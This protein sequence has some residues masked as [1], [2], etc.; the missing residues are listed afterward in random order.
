[1]KSVRNILYVLF[2]LSVVT[3][4]YAQY[5][6][7]TKRKWALS[8]KASPW[9]RPVLTSNPSDKSMGRRFSVFSVMGEYYLPKKITAEAG[10]FRAEI[11][12]GGHTRT[13]EGLQLGGKKRFVDPDFFIQPYA[14]AATQFNWGRHYEKFNFDDG[15]YQFTRNPRL[16]FVSGIGAEL[17]LL[18]SI[19]FV[20]GYNFNIGIDS[21][22]I[23]D[24]KP[25]Y[26]ESAYLLKDKG[27][28]HN[29]ELGVKITFPFTLTEEDGSTFLELLNNLIF[30]N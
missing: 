3:P 28:Y 19:A 6:E 18:S 20:I 10:Y 13:M 24:M 8:Y 5:M 29:L 23:I 27:M 30:N 2:F 17:Y 14:M 21:K 15:S 7:D 12:Y 9:V 11:S 16:S 4:A 1:M 22:T 26:N 25:M